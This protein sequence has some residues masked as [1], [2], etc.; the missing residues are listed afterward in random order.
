MHD[1][2]GGQVSKQT[3]VEI[4]KAAINALHYFKHV[5]F[6]VEKYL[7]KVGIVLLRIMLL[8]ITIN[9]SVAKTTSYQSCILST[10]F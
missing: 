5:V 4:T 3:V 9:F 6:L 1:C 7:A 10:R 8:A 2:K